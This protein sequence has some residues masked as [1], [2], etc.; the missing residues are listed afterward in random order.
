M[1]SARVIEAE[2]FSNGSPGLRDGLVRFEI[3]L[4]IFAGAPQ[5]FNEDI[6]SPATLA[7]HADADVVLFE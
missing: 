2:I 4:L 3:H 1:G 5:P 7:I 6:V